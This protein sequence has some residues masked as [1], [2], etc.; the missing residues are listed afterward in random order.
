MK[1]I[2]HVIL[3]FFCISS[4]SQEKEMSILFKDKDT[5]AL[6]EDVT[7]TI[8]R[9]K[10]NFVS[11]AE[12]IV[13]FK[14]NRIVYIEISHFTYKTQII[15]STVLIADE[16]VFFLESNLNAL[17]EVVLTKD[18]PQLILKKVVENSRKK[19][20]IPANLRVYLREFFKQ[21]EVS[22]LYNDGLINYQIF[23]DAKGIKTDILVE[24]NRLIG[25]LSE[26]SKD[27]IFYGFDLNNLMENYY[28]FNY[29]NE[30]LDDKSKKKYSYQL[31]SFP[32]ND[33]ILEIEVKPL[34]GI[35]GFLFNYSIL[36]DHEKKLIL[37]INSNVS[38]ERV[39]SNSNFS[40]SG[41]NKVYKSDLKLIYKLKNTDYFLLNAKEVIGFVDKKGKE[42]VRTEVRNYFV[43]TKFSPSV[44]KYNESDIFKEKTLLNKPNSILTNF[45]EEDSGLLLTNEELEFIK[46]I[47]LVE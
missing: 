2:I 31:N 8:L 41:K 3:I 23:K 14:I 37:E 45:W 42:E 21:N 26:K 30:I 15:K 12:G 7:V 32:K 24:Q 10:E 19:L 39:L 35:E 1:R 18:H 11:N 25:Y 38:N 6:I 29:L 22:L 43:T 40:I 36:Y 13:K 28:Q 47:N 46:G 9:T 44:F 16:N 27:E 5:N 4:F 33:D 20:S 17:R 34:D